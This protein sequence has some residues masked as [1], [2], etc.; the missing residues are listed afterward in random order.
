MSFSG[1]ISP[2]GMR[3]TTEYSPPRWML[4]RKRSLVSWSVAWAGS[5]MFSFQI[6]ARIEATAGLQISQPWPLAVRGDQGVERLDPLDHRD[7]V[8]LLAAVREVLAEPV[9]DPGA[10]RLELGLEQVGDARQA[11]AAAGAGL[12]A[13]LDL[14]DG[15]QLPVADRLADL[16]LADVVARADLGV[17]VA[18]AGGARAR[19]A[20]AGRR[21]GPGAASRSGTGRA[22][23][24]SPT[25]SPTRTPPSRRV[26]SESKTSFL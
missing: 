13:R 5:R 11:A 3:G 9:V 2:P 12:R 6:V 18:A 15:G 23:C 10:R 26:P 8:E 21:A 20:R 25:A 14:R 17:A 4:A 19:P 16:T 24:R 22:A 1:V 7:L